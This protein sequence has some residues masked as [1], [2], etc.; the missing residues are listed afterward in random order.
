MVELNSI[1]RHSRDLISETSGFIVLSQLRVKKI[2]LVDSNTN[3][4]LLNRS[5]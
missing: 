2:Y 4:V 1:M 5:Y 3:E